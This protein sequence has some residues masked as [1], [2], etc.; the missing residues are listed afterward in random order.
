MTSGGNPGG[1]IDLVLPRRPLS[2]GCRTL[3]QNFPRDPV[4]DRGP[5]GDQVIGKVIVRVMECGLVQSCT[6]H[7]HGRFGIPSKT[8]K[9]QN[10]KTPGEMR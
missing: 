3:P 10:P 2:K 7:H 9:P 4:K 8:P 1:A 6:Q 5:D